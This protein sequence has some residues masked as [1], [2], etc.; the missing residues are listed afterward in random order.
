M[1]DGDSSNPFV[2]MLPMGFS[3]MLLLH[4]APY[5]VTRRRQRYC[6][7]LLQSAGL[8]MNTS[9]RPLLTGFII[10]SAY[11]AQRKEMPLPNRRS[12]SKISCASSTINSR[13]AR[14]EQ[15]RSEV[16][17]HPAV[18]RSRS[19]VDVSSVCVGYGGR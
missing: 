9:T 19:P 1:Y 12:A 14:S 3:M 7:R 5:S 2:A 18:S 13:T 4:I 11:F 17:H 10:A 15:P 6:C 8:R 16:L